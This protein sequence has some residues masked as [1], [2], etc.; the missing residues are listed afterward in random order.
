[1]GVSNERKIFRPP[2]A[3]SSLPLR[4][5]LTRSGLIGSS[6]ESDGAAIVVGRVVVVDVAVVVDIH[7]VSGVAGCSR[8]CPPV[9]AAIEQTYRKQ[10]VLNQSVWCFYA[11]QR[12]EVLPGRS[13][14]RIPRLRPVAGD[15]HPPCPCTMYQSGI[16]TDHQSYQGHQLPLSA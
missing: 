12:E 9:V 16:A 8:E 1:M 2:P 3:C 6:L 11:M 13:V 7:K 5:R 14:P 15:P 4:G 10:P